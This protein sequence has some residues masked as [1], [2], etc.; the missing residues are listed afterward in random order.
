ME[1]V[2]LCTF[3]TRA[4]ADFLFL[5]VSRKDLMVYPIF[6]LSS[7]KSPCIQCPVV[8]KQKLSGIESKVSVTSVF[9][10]EGRNLVKSIPSNKTSILT[11]SCIL[12]LIWLV[13]SS[14]N[15]NL[16]LRKVSFE[17]FEDTSRRSILFAPFTQPGSHIVVSIPAVTPML[18]FPIF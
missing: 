6:F 16:L 11:V 18:Y 7:P 17:W 12:S 14:V 5:K 4:G 8:K 10:E 15:S 9:S 13:F 2:I 3:I 1:V